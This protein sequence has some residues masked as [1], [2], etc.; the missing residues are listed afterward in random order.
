M[1]A[2]YM[3]VLGLQSR[4]ELVLAHVLDENTEYREWFKMNSPI[5][6][7]RGK[8]IGIKRIMDNG[9]FELGASIDP[10]V[11]IELGTMCQATHLVLP[12]Y[13]GE[14]P[15]KTID[16]A[17]EWAPKFRKEGFRTIFVPQGRIGEVKDIDKGIRFAVRNK[18]HDIPGTSVMNITATFAANLE[19]GENLIDE[20]AMSILAIPNAYGV[21]KN[22]TQ[23]FL[24][25]WRYMSTLQQRDPGL[26]KDFGQF[27][28]MPIHMLGLLDGPNEI[29]L[30]QQMQTVTNYNIQSWDSSAAVWYAH[31]EVPFDNSPTGSIDGKFEL[32]VDFRAPCDPQNVYDVFKLDAAIQNMRHIDKLCGY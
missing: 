18:A 21:Y 9:A 3:A 32:E 4:C 13:P 10:N 17:L 2:R 26:Y 5:T 19:G 29:S 16:A 28:A 15:Q 23:R 25:R 14:D 11:L 12:D 31:N 24:A 1:P 20:V 6:Q 27:G 22:K 7:I 8:T 30:I